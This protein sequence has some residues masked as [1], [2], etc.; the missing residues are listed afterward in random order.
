MLLLGA[1]GVRPLSVVLSCASPREL[2]VAPAGKVTTFPCLRQLKLEGG[3]PLRQPHLLAAT[4]SLLCAL[5]EYGKPLTLPFVL[6][7]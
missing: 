3:H 1:L 6:M 2:F 4:L 7:H 5:G